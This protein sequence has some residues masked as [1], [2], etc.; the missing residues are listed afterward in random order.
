MS[1]GISYKSY[2]AG[3]NNFEGCIM[4]KK[5]P[6]DS[7]RCKALVRVCSKCSKRFKGGDRTPN[8]PQCNTSRRCR[9]RRV[10]DSEYCRVHGAKAG[11]PKTFGM[12]IAQSLNERYNRIIQSPELWDMLESQVLL[13]VRLEQLMERLDDLAKEG[14]NVDRVNELLSQ[15]ASAISRE[16]KPEAYNAITLIRQEIS[17]RITE[18]YLWGKMYEVIR[19]IAYQSTQKKNIDIKTDAM[20]SVAEMMEFNIFIQSIMFKYILNP[21]D[22]EDCLDEISGN[23]R[24]KYIASQQS[25]LPAESGN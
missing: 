5:P 22:R 8:C 18:F 15:C 20:I 14:I 24:E 2:R 7:Q 9:N 17:D 4:A 11:R 25:I 23:L 12:R 3:R 16:N 13:K 10:G 21:N 6:P 19:M 1:G